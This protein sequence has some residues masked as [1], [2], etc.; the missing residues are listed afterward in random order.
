MEHKINHSWESSDAGQSPF[1]FVTRKPAVNVEGRTLNVTV[2]R[3]KDAYSMNSVVLELT[4][5]GL[6]HLG[7]ELIRI[8]AAVRAEEK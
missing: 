6:E 1:V 4:S 8:A 3:A 5:V 2:A 7:M